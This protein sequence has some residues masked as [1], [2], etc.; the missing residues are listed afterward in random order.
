MIKR[1]DDFIKW[2]KKNNYQFSTTRDFLENWTQ[3]NKN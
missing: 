2:A 1:F 3:K